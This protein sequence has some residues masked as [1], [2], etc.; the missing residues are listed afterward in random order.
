M[1]LR[2]QRH[3]SEP[4]QTEHG[5]SQRHN[6][7]IRFALQNSNFSKPLSLWAFWLADRLNFA[8]SRPARRRVS[9]LRKPLQDQLQSRL[10]CRLRSRAPPQHQVGLLRAADDIAT[11]ICLHC[12]QLSTSGFIPASCGTQ[13]TEQC[14]DESRSARRSRS[15]DSDRSC[16]NAEQRAPLRTEPQ[17]RNAPRR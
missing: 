15:C 5:P 6:T 14:A 11:G 4:I 13:P 9:K 8:A 12:S 7:V 17:R 16:P 2:P 1:P 3:S 10:L